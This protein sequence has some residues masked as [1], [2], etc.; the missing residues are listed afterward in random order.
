MVKN[1]QWSRKTPHDAKAMTGTVLCPAANIPNASVLLLETG[2]FYVAPVVYQNILDPIQ[3]E[4][5][6]ADDVPPAPSK[7]IRGKTSGTSEARGESGDVGSG[8]RPSEAAGFRDVGLGS[9]GAGSGGDLEGEEGDEFEG[10]V[11]DSVLF[12]GVADSHVLGPVDGVEDSD[13]HVSLRNLWSEPMTC[14]LCDAARTCNWI[15]DRCDLCGTWQGK[16]LSR[17]ESEKEAENLLT[18]QG[19]VSRCDLNHLLAT[20]LSGWTAKS[21]NCDREAAKSGTSGLYLGLYTYGSRV[22]ITNSCLE[23]PNLTKLLNRYLKQNTQHV[24][25]FQ[26]PGSSINKNTCIIKLMFQVRLL[27]TMLFQLQADALCT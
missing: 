3:F 11:P 17:E 16:I 18:R 19:F 7:R 27:S 5:H 12:D 15:A 13:L 9:R 25:S 21:R 8:L 2:Q 6:V 20:S 4:G 23:R 26:R 24:D 22:G 10:M 1:R 14:K